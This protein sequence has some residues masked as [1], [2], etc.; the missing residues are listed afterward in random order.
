M[1]IS[2]L[3][4]AVQVWRLINLRGFGQRVATRHETFSE[5]IAGC[6]EEVL[7]ALSSCERTVAKS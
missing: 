6:R 2:I 1:I 7:P 4:R 3:R 5:P